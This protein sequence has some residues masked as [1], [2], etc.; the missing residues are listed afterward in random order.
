MEPAS[1]ESPALAGGFFTTSTTSY[2]RC[3]HEGKP[4]EGYLGTLRY[5]CNFCVSYSFE[6]NS[7]INNN[8]LQ[9]QSL[10][11]KENEDSLHGQAASAKSS[12]SFG[13]L[14]RQAVA[15]WPQAVRELGY[16]RV[17]ELSGV[18]LPNSLVQSSWDR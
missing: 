6:L 14:S 16:S 2:L 11:R 7:Y 17:K 5:L 12:G 1:L 8:R 13:W 10:Q 4:G 15:L 18:C 3:Y 9:S